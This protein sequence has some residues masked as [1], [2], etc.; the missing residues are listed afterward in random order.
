[1]GP[2]SK[3][4]RALPDIMLGERSC[5]SQRRSSSLIPPHTPEAWPVSIAQARHWLTTGQPL[6]TDLASASWTCAG[7]VVPMGKNSSG[8]SVRQA[9]RWRQLMSITPIL[10]IVSRHRAGRRPTASH[11]GEP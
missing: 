3:T 7:S 4:T 11:H 2:T 9:A 10:L 5:R 1:L 8:S 6:H